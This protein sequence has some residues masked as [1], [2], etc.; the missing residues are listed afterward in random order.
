[1]LTL[2]SGVVKVAF[3]KS[4]AVINS[5]APYFS[6]SDGY[7]NTGELVTVGEIGGDVEFDINFQEREFYGQSNFPIAKAFFG[8]K[9]DI[10]A[11]G[12]EINWDNVKN[13]FHVSL[14]ESKTTSNTDLPLTATAYG[15]AHNNFS[16]GSYS[17]NFKP[18][19]GRPNTSI[20]GVT[21]LMGLPRPLYVKFEH[22]RSDDPSKSVIIHL[23]KAYS[24]QLMM[25]F[26]REDIARQDLDFSAVVDRDCKETISSS[27][28][29]PSVVLIEA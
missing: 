11:R 16:G 18:D 27:S 25:P 22:I 12:V 17:V 21:A 15:Y 10:R 26:T 19:G 28:A 4:G 14:G 20:T 1:M 2:G 6:T 23:P 9:A 24:M 29:T 8:G 5:A 7:G 3:W 13:L